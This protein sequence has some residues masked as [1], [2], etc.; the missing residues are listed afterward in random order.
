MPWP[1]PP[2]KEIAARIA[3]TLESGLQIIKPLVDPL[4]ISRAVRSARGVFA[5]IIR[6]VSLEIRQLHDHLSWWARQWFPDTAED[7][8]ILRHAGIWGVPRRAATKAVGTLVIEGE[9]GTNIPALTEFA[10]SDG[11]TFLSNDLVIIGVGG[12]VDIAVTAVVAGLDG[13]VEADIGLA[14]VAPFPEIATVLVGPEGTAGGSD[15]ESLA[16]VQSATLTR[17]RQ[18]GHGGAGFDYPYWIG[19]AF[20]VEA[21][22]TLPGWFGRGSVG[23]AVVMRVDDAF[24]RAPIEDELDAMLTYLGPLNSSTGVRPVTAHVV[25]LS[26]VVTPIDISVRL[27]PDTEDIR[28]AVTEAFSR[29]IATVGDE[30]D[31]INNGPIGATLEPSRISEAI[32][33]AGGEYAHDLTV[34]AAQLVLDDKGYPTPGVITWLDPA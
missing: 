26:G 15:I 10:V 27:R 19:R 20:D 28:T 21:V 34:P 24:G 25:V 30:E 32:S 13:N 18:R 29:F 22:R 12:S 14:T 17:I 2:A 6:A 9:A 7:E 16:S 23:V 11:V 4:A 1:I 5:Q 33:S 8:F 31:E 3:G